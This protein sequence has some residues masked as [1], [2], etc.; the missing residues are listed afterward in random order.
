[1]Q[2]K[3][4][5][6]QWFSKWEQGDFHNLPISEN[7]KHTSPYGTIDGKAAYIRLVDANKE[8]F[9]NH[10]FDIH[11]ELYGDNKACIRYTAKKKNFVLEV[12]EWHFF[13]NGLIE[14]IVSYYNIEG[15]VSEERK[16]VKPKE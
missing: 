2:F 4:V 1:M 10:H 15:E 3:S 12:S 7:F 13:K 16:L 14:E 5:V 6:H 9:L 11:D 8:Q